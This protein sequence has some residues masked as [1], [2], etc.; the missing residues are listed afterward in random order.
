MKRK[1]NSRILLV[2]T[3]AAAVVVLLLAFAHKK[4]TT[5]TVPESGPE[6]GAPEQTAPAPE[7]AVSAPAGIDASSAAWTFD[8]YETAMAG[9]GRKS[10]IS[11]GT[12][13]A[14]RARS[15]TAHD[16]VANYLTQHFGSADP[17]VLRA[18]DE[19]PREYFHYNYQTGQSS[20][21][22]AYEDKVDKVKAWAIGYG[23]ALSD[24][25]GQAYMTEL[26]QPKPTDVALEI[27][28]G[29][30]YQSALLSRIVKKMYSIEIIKPLGEAVQKIYAPLGYDNIETKVGDGF[31]GWPEVSGGFDDI[32][33]TAAAQYV[34]PALIDQLKPGGR[35]VIPV[36]QPFKRGQFLYVYTKDADG[37]VHSKKDIGVYFIPFT[38]DISKTPASSGN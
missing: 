17:A 4:Q 36:G 9:S 34:P 5:E 16:I 8:A 30:G 28:T 7:P 27:G 3:A 31:Y 20:A 19:V 26:L 15:K 29:S 38:G 2:I 24:Y 10:N 1:S 22:S 25:L 11:S 21:S 14:I 23:S 18:F 6:A 33:V 12:F 35:M 32:I 13:D 37:K